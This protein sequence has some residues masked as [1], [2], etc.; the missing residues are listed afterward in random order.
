MVN[1][2]IKTAPECPGDTGGVYSLDNSGTVQ[3]DEGAA[4]WVTGHANYG[5]L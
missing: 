4:T 1:G 2:Y 3:G 5:T